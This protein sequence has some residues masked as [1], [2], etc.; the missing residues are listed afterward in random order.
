MNPSLILKTKPR[1]KA[2]QQPHR[3]D[4][5]RFGRL[6]FAQVAYIAGIKPH[7]A[8]N[9]Y[10]RQGLRGDALVE[11]KGRLRA[12][13][14]LKAPVR[15]P[16]MLLACKLAHAFPDRVPTWR[17]IAAVH[18]MS[19]TAAIRWRAAMAHARGDV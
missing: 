4:A 17:E 2:G 8:W 19:K 10:H 7:S 15:V 6:T 3:V 5:G 16:S 1:R 18:P 12:P 9:R 13:G 11:G 14:A